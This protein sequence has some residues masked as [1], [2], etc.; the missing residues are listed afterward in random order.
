MY[1]VVE[2]HDRFFEDIKEW[3]VTEM[4]HMVSLRDMGEEVTAFEAEF[5]G[6]EKLFR[7]IP[8]VA[9]ELILEGHSR[10]NYY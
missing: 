4:M 8:V 5:G 2:A 6:E 7:L 9:I 3:L 10:Y 1:A